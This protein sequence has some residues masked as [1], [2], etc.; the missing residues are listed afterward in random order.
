MFA[1]GGRSGHISSPSAEGIL[2]AIGPGFRTCDE[3]EGLGFTLVVGHL[4]QLGVSKAAENGW[5]SSM[6]RDWVG[7]GGL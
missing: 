6:A 1:F 3:L 4:G 5:G 7:K 2:H